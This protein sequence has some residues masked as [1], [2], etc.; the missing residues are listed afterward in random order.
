MRKRY[1]TDLKDEEW[2]IIA[3]LVPAAKLGGR[4]R[5]TDVRE[6]LNAIFYILKTGCPW[7]FLPDGFPPKSTVY[8][9]FNTW[10]QDG[11]WQ[12]IHDQLRRDTR[13]ASGKDEEPSV[14]IIDSQSVKTTEI[15]GVK[16][17]DA[18]KKTKGRK[19]HILVD[20]LG[21]L[22]L[23]VVHSAGIQDRDGAKLIFE[24]AQHWLPRI[25]LIWA[26]A[27]YAGKLI[28]WLGHLC[29][30]TLDIIKR[31]TDAKGFILLPK[32]WVVERTFAWLS[33][34]RRFSKDYE[35][36][37]DNSEAM[38]QIAMIHIMLRRLPKLRNTS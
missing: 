29:S 38:M 12:N 1:S 19:R 28:E 32:R 23:V 15:G 3:P 24:K 11:T 35:F 16:G 37:T 6:V 2:E 31:P 14:G 34:Y 4:P 18:G 7:S 21:L 13:T 25:R 9:Y 36:F 8:H 26:D 20:S 22:L 5:T 30:W 33:N 17:Y 27:A 10:S